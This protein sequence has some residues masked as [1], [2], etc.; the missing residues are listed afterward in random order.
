LLTPLQWSALLATTRKMFE[1]KYLFEFE[2]MCEFKVDFN[3]GPRLICFIKKVEVKNLV[4][5]SL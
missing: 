3:Q 1:F 2:I 4:G 5:L